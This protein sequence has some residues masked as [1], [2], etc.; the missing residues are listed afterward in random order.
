MANVGI[1]AQLGS[2]GWQAAPPKAASCA[3]WEQFEPLGAPVGRTSELAALKSALTEAGSAGAII[4]GP[5]GVG[6]TRLAREAL[7]RARAGG[8]TTRWL[9]A[10][11]TADAASV[12]ADVAQRAAGLSCCVLGI[13]DVHALDQRTVGAIIELA[14]SGRVRLLLTARDGCLT[15]VTQALLDLGQDGRCARVDLVP[16]SRP[17][18]DDFAVA[19]IGGSVDAGT[20]GRLWWMARGNA[21]CISELIRGGLATGQLACSGGTWSWGNLEMPDDL[22]H[23]V[24]GRIG[25]AGDEQAAAL[26]L[27]AAAEPVGI[28]VLIRAGATHE[29]LERLER[30]GVVAVTASGRRLMVATADPMIADAVR[31]R[32]GRLRSRSL[33]MRL[34]QAWESAAGQRGEDAVRLASLVL[35]SGGQMPCSMGVKAA[36]CA[37]DQLDFALAERIARA[38]LE[39][40]GGGPAVRELA[41]ALVL[42]GKMHEAQSLLAG[43]GESL[44]LDP[45]VQAAVAETRANLQWGL[46]CHERARKLLSSVAS[47]ET[48]GGRGTYL[49]AMH[50]RC[51]LYESRFGDAVTAA[52]R[53]LRAGE[54]EVR[55]VDHATVTAVAGLS[56]LGRTHEAIELGEP[57]LLAMTHDPDRPGPLVREELA[58]ALCRA[59]LVHG[60]P[61]S[62]WQ[63]AGAGHDRAT[64]ARLPLLAAWWATHLGAAASA[65]GRG[66]TAL[67]ILR[68]AVGQIPRAAD[69][70]QFGPVVRHLAL[71]TLARV[72]AAA[73]ELD[74]AEQALADSRSIGMHSLAFL[75]IWEPDAAVWLQSARVRTAQAI[76]EAL[77]V[78]DRAAEVGAAG[79][80]LRALHHVVR[81]GH[82]AKVSERV[83]ALAPFVDGHLAEAM[84][85]HA[86]A[87]VV[88]D[89]RGLELAVARFADADIR[90]I[91]DCSIGSVDRQCARLRC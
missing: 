56:A 25:V 61:G 89:G 50:A 69:G 57:A 3:G 35:A 49:M 74:L 28:G 40:G 26:E 11:V 79:V 30:A 71:R 81:L 27:V 16:F 86:R 66:L 7:F 91:G 55:D 67:K 31:R 44:A 5:A 90:T 46:G 76:D 62:A 84:A 87:A 54:S 34:V 17:E 60:R 33:Q 24:E 32:T 1:Q 83:Q 45:D 36:R 88:T 70:H 52:E 47:D 2:R 80:E 19:R 14:S 18:A 12:V 4:V 48:A 53:V 73:G 59:Y 63:L 43:C 77:A 58:S 37:V 21:S 13:D 9:P 10:A 23:L 20:L 72:A 38:A 15:P 78:A 8:A 6:R 29:A 41:N 68:D 65:M 75:Q 22:A 85:L 39:E 82:A 42:Q 51:L 64:S